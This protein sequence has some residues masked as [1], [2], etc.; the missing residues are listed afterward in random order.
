MDLLYS[1]LCVYHVFR[2]KVAEI[3]GM[4]HEHTLN[5]KH[6]AYTYKIDDMFQCNVDNTTVISIL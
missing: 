3:Y 2:S 6:T 1:L 5:S 4:L